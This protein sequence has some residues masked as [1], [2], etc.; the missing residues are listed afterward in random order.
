MKEGVNRGVVMLDNDGVVFK[1]FVG[2]V[3]RE[4]ETI[5]TAGHQ[6]RST[7][8]DF[9]VVENGCVIWH[10]QLTQMHER[11]EASEELRDEQE[12]IMRV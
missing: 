11:K 12:V 6:N 1:E 10:Y 3:A 9:T 5:V 4:E 2:L 7:G 8:G